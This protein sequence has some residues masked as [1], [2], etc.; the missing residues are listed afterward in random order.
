MRGRNFTIVQRSE[1][2]W[3]AVRGQDCGDFAD[4]A[5]YHGVGVCLINTSN[6]VNQHIASVYLVQPNRFGWHSGRV[7]ETSA[8]LRDLTTVVSD[9][10][11]QV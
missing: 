9:V 4:S 10:R 1:Y 2:H 11:S 7:P 8:I 3:Q 6:R 5:V